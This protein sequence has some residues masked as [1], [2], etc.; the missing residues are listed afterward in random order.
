MSRKSSPI[1][2]SAF[3][4]IQGGLLR[5]ALGAAVAAA[6]GLAACAV[7]IQNLQ[8]AKELAKLAEPPGSLD[9]GW[10]VFQDKCAGCHGAAATG[11]AAAPDLLPKV[12]EMGTRRFV[13]LV[14]RRYDW[15]LPLGRASGDSAAREALID[16]VM[17]RKQG[18]VSMPAWEGG[19]SVTA[20]I[21]DIY[22]WL[23]ARAEG[24]QGPGRPA[25][26]A[27]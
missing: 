13:G 6:L 8:P 18:A 11:T 23:S 25:S 15:N 20:H 24:K 3:R 22:A 10:R 12:C 14:L 26:P 16:E 1:A 19:P 9:A 21:V 7:E 27:R 5:L 2:G 4:R 17:Q